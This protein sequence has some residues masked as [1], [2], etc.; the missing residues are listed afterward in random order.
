MLSEK[1]PLV[2]FVPVRMGKRARG[3]EKLGEGLDEI[4]K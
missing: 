2:A 1:G 3:R 4:V